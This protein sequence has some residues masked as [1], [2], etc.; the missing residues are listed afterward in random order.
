MHFLSTMPWDV[1]G[2]RSNDTST[3]TAG[4]NSILTSDSSS[5]LKSILTPDFSSCL[6]FILTG[7]G[8]VVGDGVIEVR[9]QGNMY[10]F[11]EKYLR[12][13]GEVLTDM[14]RIGIKVGR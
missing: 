1:E 9:R 14:E 13:F 3:S 10:M 4:M 5:C 6:N 12:K 7:D 2:V 8:V 11:Y